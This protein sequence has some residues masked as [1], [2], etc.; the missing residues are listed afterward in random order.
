MK[1]EW[2]KKRIPQRQKPQT[3][4]KIF[5]QLMLGGK[6]IAAIWLLD[7]DSSGALSVSADVIKSIK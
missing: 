6:V 4:P 7:D 2:S 5:A 3:K 1:Q